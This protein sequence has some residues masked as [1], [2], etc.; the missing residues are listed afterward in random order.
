MESSGRG[1]VAADPAALAASLPE[2]VSIFSW[3]PFSFVLMVFFLLV[4]R[5]MGS[6]DIVR[7]FCAG[8]GPMSTV[9]TRKT[10]CSQLD[11]AV[12]DV[13]RVTVAVIM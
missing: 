1:D 8:I 11:V 5:D 4:L 12:M 10:F 13:G 9:S 6:K 2:P 3:D 7:G